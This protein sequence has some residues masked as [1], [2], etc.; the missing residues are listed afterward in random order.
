MKQVSRFEANLLRIVRGILQRAPLEQVLPLVPARVPPRR[1]RGRE[2]VVLFQDMLGRGTV[3]LLAR[4]GW[5][6]ER[7]VRDTTVADGRLWQRTPPADLAL[8]FSQ[9][10]LGFLI[11]LTAWTPEDK[12]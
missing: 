2:A 6:R 9:H 1:C 8:M 5:R 4:D 12:E 10:T 7:F 11:W 3:W